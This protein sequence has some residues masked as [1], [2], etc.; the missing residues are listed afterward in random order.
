MPSP[1]LLGVE[2]REV[3]QIQDVLT[4]IRMFYRWTVLDLGRVASLSLSLLPKVS[5]LYL[6]T[7]VSVPALHEAKRTI[8]VLM[9]AG[10]EPDHLRLIVN[11]VGTQEFSGSEL[12]RLF[13]VPVYAKLPGAARELD[14]ACIRGQLLGTNSDYRTQVAGVAR[15]I[16]GLPAEMSG[17]P[18]AHL[19]SFA[20]KFRRSNK[21]VAA[22]T[23]A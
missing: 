1:N 18:V 19:R 17:G 3:G 5:E 7:T 14:D 22:A 8:G 12:T 15:K 16:A 2:R 10:L 6:V 13:G 4:L 11:Q 23:G 20:S 9:R 21:D